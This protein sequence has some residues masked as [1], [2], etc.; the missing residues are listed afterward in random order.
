MNLSYFKNPRR[1]KN[2]LAAFNGF[3]LYPLDIIPSGSQSCGS[4]LRSKAKRNSNPNPNGSIHKTYCIR[5]DQIKAIIS[6]QMLAVIDFRDL[7]L[8]ASIRMLNLNPTPLKTWRIRGFRENGWQTDHLVNNQ[9]L[10]NAFH[11]PVGFRF[12]SSV[13][14]RRK[15]NTGNF[16]GSGNFE[17]TVYKNNQW[18]NAYS[19]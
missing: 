7:D 8:D 15:N 14:D 2:P 10:Q 11:A 13:N 6:F 3:S 9:P 4:G 18:S 12:R 5:P 1:K 16:W 19:M 17:K